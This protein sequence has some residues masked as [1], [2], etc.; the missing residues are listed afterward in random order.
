MPS[1]NDE[2]FPRSL[3]SQ[4][5][6]PRHLG[7]VCCPIAEYRRSVEA[8]LR[9][10]PIALN[11]CAPQE[12]VR[13]IAGVIA[14]WARLTGRPEGHF[15][16]TKQLVY[17]DRNQCDA[18]RDEGVVDPAVT[19]SSEYTPRARAR[20]ARAY[21][22]A[23]SAPRTSGDGGSVRGGWLN[24][25]RDRQ[26]IKPAW[27]KLV[28]A[29]REKTGRI[30]GTVAAIGVVISVLAIIY[31]ATRPPAAPKD[32]SHL[33]LLLPPPAALAPNR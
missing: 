2:A 12:V 14:A 26:R 22:R 1:P 5:S 29:N 7:N 10:P 11:A 18:N 20:L 15:Q 16:R 30:V 4:S 9:K 8:Q 25:P 13:R 23:S 27:Y 24:A 28:M 32:V 19:L 17:A 3:M 33:H 6:P 31:M 21:C